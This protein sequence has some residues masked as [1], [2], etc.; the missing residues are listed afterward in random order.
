M[1]LNGHDIQIMKNSGRIVRFRF[2]GIFPFHNSYQFGFRMPSN[3]QQYFSSPR[4][5]LTQCVVDRSVYGD[6]FDPKYS[7]GRLM[8]IPIKACLLVGSISIHRSLHC[9]I[10]V[11]CA[12][13]C[14]LTNVGWQLGRN[15]NVTPTYFKI[16]CH[17]S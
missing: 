7:L 13:H 3:R 11:F 12:I 5:S 16:I 1:W 4:F 9:G 6:D 17:H 8:S 2:D 15:I 14:L 10:D